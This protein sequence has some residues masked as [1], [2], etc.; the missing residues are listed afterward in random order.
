MGLSFCLEIPTDYGFAEKVHRPFLRKGTELRE[1]SKEEWDAHFPNEELVTV[2]HPDKTLNVISRYFHNR[3]IPAALYVGIHQYLWKPNHKIRTAGDLIPYLKNSIEL[4]QRVDYRQAIAK[5]P[6]P[7]S[8][9]GAIELLLLLT[10]LLT[11]C[12]DNFEATVKIRECD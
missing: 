9:D 5:L 6:E 1:L 7:M 4:L 11:V 12:Q 8:Y 3:T 10:E 2:D